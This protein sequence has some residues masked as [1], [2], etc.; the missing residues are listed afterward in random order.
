MGIDEELC[1][2]LH[3]SYFENLHYTK[4]LLVH[5]NDVSVDVTCAVGESASRP[6]SAPD[7]PESFPKG[8]FY[9]FSSDYVGPEAFDSLSGM[10]KKCCPDCSLYV[11]KRDQRIGG[12]GT[13]GFELRC[14]CYKVQKERMES[15]FD[16][17]CFTK[18]GTKPE[19]VKKQRTANQVT[20]TDRMS[21]SKMKSR[22]VE[23]TPSK[24][25][26]PLEE[27]WEMKNRTGSSRAK[28]QSMRCP[29]VIRLLMIGSDGRYYLRADSDLNHRHHH[30][31]PPEANSL[32]ASDLNEDEEAWIAQMYKM[33]M[34]N[35][36]IAGVMSGYMQGKGVAGE[37]LTH[38]IKT[39]TSKLTREMEVL[40]GI[41][42]DF[43]VAEKTIAQLNE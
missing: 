13:L 33:G 2:S 4:S 14:G 39:I 15:D 34:S 11:Q 31:M 10:L 8:T 1:D 27:D 37:F 28:S 41:D 22:L 43:S 38:T 25:P 12:F 42:S 9:R 18:R 16:D 29:A 5:H 6:P 35:G 32:T 17:G 7:Q 36:V 21:N 26:N 23:R 19:T 30:P 24:A 40:A 20:T 3:E